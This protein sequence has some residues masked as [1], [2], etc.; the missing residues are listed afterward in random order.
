MLIK[1]IK[2]TP[3]ILFSFSLLFSYGS[4]KAQKLPNKQT[5]GIKTPANIKVDGKATEWSDQYQAYNNAT[6]VYYTIANTDSVI[7]LVVHATKPQVIQ[8]VLENGITFSILK[9]KTTEN[10]NNVKILFPSIR[11]DDCWKI[12]NG[13][14]LPISGFRK[15]PGAPTHAAFSP[16]SILASQKEYSLEGA[17]KQLTSILKDIRFIGIET[18]KDTVAGITPK[19]PYY[20]NFALRY[21]GYK[22]ISIYNEDNIQAA[23]QFDDKKELTYELSFPTRYI[24]NNIANAAFN[25]DITVNARDGS[26]PGVVVFYE[27]PP[28]RGMAFPELFNATNLEGEYTL[29]K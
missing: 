28:N 19:S 12:M 24:K 1:S 8:K 20:R 5:V 26:R 9:N 16:D 15:M 2:I 13:V 18:I 11:F 17:N 21:E 4:L 6:E 3:A 25:Y 29:A 22:Y 23:I 7:T 27:P 14:G 10:S